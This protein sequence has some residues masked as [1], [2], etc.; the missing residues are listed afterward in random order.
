[1][2]KMVLTEVLSINISTAGALKL[3]RKEEKEPSPECSD[4]LNGENH[5]Y[6]YIIQTQIFFKSETP[7]S[8]YY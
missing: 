5:I 3:V 4:F 7:S 2:A 1:M 8:D 6:S